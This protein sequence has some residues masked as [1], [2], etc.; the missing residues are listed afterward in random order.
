MKLHFINKLLFIFDID[1]ILKMNNN[2]IVVTPQ[3]HD[4]LT[5]ITFYT[6][7]SRAVCFWYLPQ[8]F[9]SALTA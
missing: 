9:S 1:L 2:G 3:L 7:W 8:A 6:F 4:G 5:M